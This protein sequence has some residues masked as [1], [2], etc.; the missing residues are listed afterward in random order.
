[1][2][3]QIVLVIAFISTSTA[4]TVSYFLLNNWIVETSDT[5]ICNRE[6]CCCFTNQVN[7]YQTSGTNELHVN[8]T[9]A[10]SQCEQTVEQDNLDPPTSFIFTQEFFGV[11]YDFKLTN[12]TYGGAPGWS[13]SA[14]SAVKPAC[15]FTLF[16]PS[17]VPLPPAPS[18]GPVP[19]PLMPPF[20][21]PY[22][23][24]WMFDPLAC[25]ASC[26]C[27]IGS[28]TITKKPDGAPLF[29]ISGPPTI[30]CGVPPPEEDDFPWPTSGTD[31]FSSVMVYGFLERQDNYNITLS[32]IS[33]GEYSL[34]FKDLVNPICTMRATRKAMYP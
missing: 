34:V 12:S 28:T 16:H 14:V 15:S 30:G 1:M 13:F 20:A 25:N 19:P 5:A 33:A 7:V 3:I 17:K 29:L 22:I 6:V 31:T 4:Q 9:V 27:L 10:G 32:Q 23:G 21:A 2:L 18:D 11:G 24:K 8:G 26:C